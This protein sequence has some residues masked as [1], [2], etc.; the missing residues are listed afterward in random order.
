M[1]PKTRG[2]SPPG[3]RENSSIVTAALLILERQAAHVAVV[4]DHEIEEAVVDDAEMAVI[5]Q[6]L[7]ESREPRMPQRCLT[8]HWRECRC[9]SSRS[10][11]SATPDQRHINRRSGRFR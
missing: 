1:T 2:I 11:G 3:S 9:S 6:F 5:E 7:R 8:K 4:L 10:T